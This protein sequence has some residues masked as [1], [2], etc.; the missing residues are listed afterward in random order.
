M[1]GGHKGSDTTERLT[2]ALSTALSICIFVVN[3]SPKCSLRRVKDARFCTVK[4]E[5]VDRTGN[6]LG[7]Q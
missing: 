7:Q 1:H 4:N 3:V 2:L 6:L 5:A